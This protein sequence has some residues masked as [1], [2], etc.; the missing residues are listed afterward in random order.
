MS[1][2]AEIKIKSPREVA[3]NFRVPSWSK[4]TLINGKA[5]NAGWHKLRI[6][7]GETSIKIEFDM[8]PRVIN[9]DLSSEYYSGEDMRVM[10]WLGYDEA[11][12]KDLLPIMRH[13]AAATIKRGPLL[14]ARSK[15]I[16]N[17]SAEMFSSPSVNNA[18]A[19]CE[20]TPENRAIHGGNGRQ[21]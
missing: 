3:V 16:G 19:K 2:T 12:R 20:L 7:K 21:K 15:Y 10:R 6:G 5:A 17:T 14:L 1:D 4:N 8:T 18:G 11:C 9:S 13:S